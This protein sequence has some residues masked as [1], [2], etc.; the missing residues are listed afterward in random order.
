MLVWRII[1]CLSLKKSLQWCFIHSATKPNYKMKHRLNTGGKV[2]GFFL[3]NTFYL[4]E[5]WYVIWFHKAFLICLY[6]FLP[7]DHFDKHTFENDN[8][9]KF[10]NFFSNSPPQY[11]IFPILPMLR[12]EKF[13][14]DEDS[15]AGWLAAAAEH[16][17]STQEIAWLFCHFMSFWPPN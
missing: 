9:N 12:N 10:K 7:V 1:G 5:G 4:V 11:K 13:Y 2:V 15:L 17:S 16:Y 8:D 14:V 3:S 6:K